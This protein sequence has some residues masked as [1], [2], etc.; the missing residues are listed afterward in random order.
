MQDID[1]AKEYLAAAGYPDGIDLTFDTMEPAGL[2]NMALAF[3]ESVAAAGIN[4]EVV[5]H[6]RDTYWTEVWLVTPFNA[7]RWGGRP[8]SQALSLPLRSTSDWNE[9][10]W[11]NPRFDELL[12]LALTELDFQQR[13]AYYQEIQ[14]LLIELAPTS[15]VMYSPNITAH[16]NHVFGVRAFPGPHTFYRDWW[17]EK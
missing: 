5:N 14:E 11:N 2:L 17:I 8:A 7:V 10:H 1:K 15:T 3:K 4:V 16:R 12:D 6:P 9:S 13:K